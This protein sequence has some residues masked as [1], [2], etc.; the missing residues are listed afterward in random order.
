MQRGKGERRVR[1]EGE[2]EGN[3]QRGVSPESSGASPLENT[4]N[5]AMYQVFPLTSSPHSFPSYLLSRTHFASSLKHSSYLSFFPSPP[6]PSYSLFPSSFPS[7]S[8]LLPTPL[9]PC[10]FPLFL[11]YV[12]LPHPLFPSPFLTFPLIPF[13]LIYISPLSPNYY[14]SP[15]NLFFFSFLTFPL[16]L[17]L[18]L[19]L[20]PLPLFSYFSPPLFPPSFTLYS[21]RFPSPLSLTQKI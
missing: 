17:P 13:L 7:F 18:S 5:K 10:S 1:G 21:P 2:S 16:I 6:P 4:G 11:S 9:F 19:P 12:I 14:P 15:F 20:I 8:P 3:Q